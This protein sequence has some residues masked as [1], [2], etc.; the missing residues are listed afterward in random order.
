MS[1]HFQD[2]VFM[3][4]TEPSLISGYTRAILTPNAVEFNKLYESVVIILN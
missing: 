4:S 3:L 1:T 2:G